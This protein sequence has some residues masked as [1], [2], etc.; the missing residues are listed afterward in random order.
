[1]D[2]GDSHHCA[3]PF[4]SQLAPQSQRRRFKSVAAQTATICVATTTRRSQDA[5]PTAATMPSRSAGHRSFADRQSLTKLLVISQSRFACPL[6]KLTACARSAAFPAG[7]SLHA[8]NVW[9][10]RTIP[11]AKRRTARVAAKSSPADQKSRN[12]FGGTSVI[13]WSSIHAMAGTT[14][15][16]AS[17]ALERRQSTGTK[18]SA[19]EE[20][21]TSGC[22]SSAR[23]RA[24][25]KSMPTP[26]H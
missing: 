13:W 9:C 20:P 6:P 15:P 10:S 16:L 11:G 19:A 3:I 8:V 26:E 1:M 4:P 12:R 14:R 22:R 21:V 18:K 7:D 25:E 24:H 17:N 23:N 5:T 2:A